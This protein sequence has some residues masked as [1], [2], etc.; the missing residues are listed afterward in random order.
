MDAAATSTKAK[1]HHLERTAKRKKQN[2]KSKAKGERGFAQ[3]KDDGSSTRKSISQERSL[4]YE[5]P[6]NTR[7]L[8][9]SFQICCLSRELV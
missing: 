5:S 3:K 1:V 9:Y 6:C 8:S 7:N 2:K 4:D